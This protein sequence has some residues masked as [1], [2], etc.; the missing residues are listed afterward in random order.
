MPKLI[1]DDALGSKLDACAAPV[2]LCNQAGR[3][4]G[5][6]IPVRHMQTISRPSDGCPRTEDELVAMR[7]ETG[8]RPLSEIWKSLGRS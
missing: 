4:L 5:Q 7:N 1:V 8:G 2:E 6:F 3:L